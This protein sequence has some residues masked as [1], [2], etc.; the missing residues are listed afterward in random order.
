MKLN[1]FLIFYYIE[2]HSP[3]IYQMIITRSPDLLFY[4]SLDMPDLLI[5]RSL[6]GCDLSFYRSLHTF[7]LSKYRS[8]MK[9]QDIMSV[10]SSQKE[11]L[12]SNDIS[13]LVHRYE[14]PLINLD[15]KM[16]QVVIG[17]RRSGKSTMCE[18]VLREKVGNF[19]YVNFDDERL[20]QIGTGD[21]DTVLEALYRIYGEF[22]YLFLDEVQNIDGW[23]L[24]V[25]RLLRQKIHVLVTGSNSRLLSSDLMTHLTGRH[26]RI[27]LYPFSFSEYCSKQGVD[28]GSLSAKARATRKN[29]LGKYLVEGGF[30]ELLG[31]E[32]RRGY[33][34]GLLDAIINTD[35]AKRFRI[36]HKEVLRR[37][38]ATL[39]ENYCHEFVATNVARDF[40]ISDHTAENYYS[41]L[42]QAFLLVAVNRYSRKSKDRVR[43][44]K[45]YVVD[46]SLVTDKEGV[47]ASENMGWRLEN[48]VCIELLRRCRPLYRD[49]FY[50][51][52]VRNEV[53]F[54][55][56]ENGK[57][58]ELI[59]V[60]YDISSPKTMSRELNGLLVGAAALGCKK[61]TLVTFEDTETITM[62]GYTIDV[63][64]AADW[65][66]MK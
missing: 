54:V 35:I 48:V 65:L 66:C 18:K 9:I 24:F 45:M 44:E 49:V 60:C 57:A 61:L 34:A 28:I 11:E 17:V 63:V 33:V 2:L 51:K 25:N 19:A 26:N 47:I 6:G 58:L 36:R 27:S 10:L 53:D 4:R 21:L 62:N 40:G 38:A 22:Q 56:I 50:F 64:S 7:V 30:P 43:N 31:E 52:S 8:F 42:K 46:T 16:A 32:N 13:G 59:Q 29:A 1:G 23:Q 55:V 14:E 37:M 12:E 20:V 41:Y 15:S 39:S 3:E 5:Y